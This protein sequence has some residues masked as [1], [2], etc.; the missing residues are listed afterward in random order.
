MAKILVVGYN[1]NFI[2][3]RRRWLRASGHTV[4]SAET[5]GEALRR[6]QSGAYEVIVLGQTVSRQ[7]RDSL[8]ATAK[9]INPGTKILV[10]YSGTIDHA[11]LADAL[12]DVNAGAEDLL[13]AV[14]HLVMMKKL[15]QN[16]APALG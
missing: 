7:Q 14:E 4:A 15:G 3:E 10:F 16:R 5:M 12:L 8:L 13:R 2:E 9:R 11:E 6:T 1:R